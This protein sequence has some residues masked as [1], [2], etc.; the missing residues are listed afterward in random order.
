[1]SN[2][3]KPNT[4]FYENYIDRGRFRLAW[5]LALFFSVIFFSLSAITLFINLISFLFYTIV[6]VLS[7]STLLVLHYTKKYKF[8]YWIFAISASILVTISMNIIPT[9]LHYS[10]F[11]WILC[12]I[13]FTFIGLDKKIAVFFVFFHSLSIAYYVFFLLNDH[14]GLLEKRD[15]YQ[16]TA[17]VIEL[18]F[19]LSVMAYLINEHINFQNF[20]ESEL[21]K[22]NKR[23]KEQFRLIQNKSDENNILVKE[24]HHRVKNNLQIVISLLRIQSDELNSAETKKQFNEAINRIMSISLVHQ[25][26]YQE[27]ELSNINIKDYLEELFQEIARYSQRHDDVKLN[28]ET[29]PLRIGLKTVIPLGLLANEL[30]TNSFKHAFENGQKGS[31]SISISPLEDDFFEFKYS[32]S[33]QWR[34]DKKNGFGTELI[35]VLT[36]QLDGDVKRE[37]SSYSFKIKNLD[38]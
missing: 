7:I 14:F 24:V 21:T 1:M 17:T 22:A 25:K 6:F 2:L 16:Q 20:A 23:L 35:S 28:I 33:G 19:A 38:E 30:L 8:T 9:T 13:L 27:K 36:Q 12:I 34:A 18:I 11:L 3:F 32:D 4:D 10:D 5:R 15:V 29:T 31:I 26:L 37:G